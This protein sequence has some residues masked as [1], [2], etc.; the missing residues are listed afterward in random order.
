[1][2]S[3]KSDFSRRK[4]LSNGAKATAGVVAGSTLLN[5]YPGQAAVEKKPGSKMKFGLVTYL[6]GKDWDLPTLIRNCEYSGC[7]GVELR[8]EHAHG[9]HAGMNEKQR[10]EVKLRFKNSPVENVGMGCNWEFHS[11]DPDR[12]NQQIEGA[13]ADIKLSYDTG[14]IGIKVKPNALPKEVPPE[15]TMEQIGKSLNIL[16]KY[17]RDFGQ[18]I[19]VEVHGRDTQQ[20]PNMKTIFDHVTERNVGMC[21]NCNNQ[22][23]D[24]EGLEYN[25]NLV[26]NRFGDTVHIRELNDPE[27]PYQKLLDMFVA[28]DYGGWI[29]LEARSEVPDRV[30]AI[31]EQSVLFKEMV[32]KSQTK[33]G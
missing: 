10:M 18:V 31:A 24:G 6:W 26:K 14:G 16:G 3:K 15:K 7:A 20:L 25:F 23:M 1:M 30:A 9:V 5:Y 12:L 28:M 4:F 27:Y 8:V 2:S 22:D 11:P 21:W 19:R 32:Q 33:L 13:K 17:A 29:L